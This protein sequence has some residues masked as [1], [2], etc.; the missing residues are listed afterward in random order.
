M[1][2]TASPTLIL[3]SRMPV[4]GIIAVMPV[5]AFRIAISVSMIVIG[6][7]MAVPM[8]MFKQRP[9]QHNARQWNQ[10][11]IVVIGLNRLYR[12]THD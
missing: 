12:K 9:Q 1:A 7:A 11:V 2:I 3:M 6:I 8:I 5:T 4:L 10:Q